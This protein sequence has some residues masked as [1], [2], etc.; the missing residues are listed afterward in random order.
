M[1]AGLIGKKLS[2]SLSPQIHGRFYSLTDMQGS[3][4]LFE[5]PKDGLCALMDKLEGEGYTGVNVT[6]PYKT[7]IIKCLSELSPEAEAIGA[8]NTVLFSGGRRYGYNTD[9]YGLKDLLESA[10]VSV[11][12]K[13]AVILGTGGAARCALKLLRD[14]GAAAVYTASRRP[15]EADAVFGAISYGE[16]EALPRVDMLVNTTPCGMYPD[17]VCCPVSPSVIAKCGCIIDLI[18]NPAETELMAQARELGI[19]AVNGLLMLCSQAVRSQEIWNDKTYGPG[20][21]DAV[22]N[23]MQRKVYKVNFVLIGMPG[24]GKTTAGKLLAESLG[25]GFTDTDSMIEEEHG[26]ISEIFSREGEAIFRI[27]EREAAV[28]VAARRGTVISTGGGIILDKANMEALRETGTV[29]FLDRP[30]EILMSETDTSGRPLL[31]GGKEAIAALYKQRHGLYTKYADI[32]QENA[33]DAQ[34]CVSE[35]IKKLEEL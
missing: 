16:L 18:Y 20:I 12:G 23:Y 8:V 13:A 29:I 35:I 34:S 4:E 7:E 30:L 17:I 14:M 10:G 15:R 26:A 5:A 22:Y 25:M 33:S 31:S 27:Y 19:K 32:I 9:Y 6:I 28:K 21:Y 1:K 11:S 3:Y 24:S 2:H